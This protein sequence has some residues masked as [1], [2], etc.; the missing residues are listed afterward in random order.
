MRKEGHNVFV[1]IVDI[2]VKEQFADEFREAV[3]RQGHN[4]ITRE[5][6]CLGFDILQDPD[7][8]TRFTLYETYTDATTFH[9]VHRT[10]AHFK[11]YAQTT[12]AWVESKSMRCL[13]KIWPS[14]G[15]GA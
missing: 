1:V 12:A 13:L 3:L 15:S 10:T 8:Q 5:K 14:E 6:G 2:V 4:S 11:E 7:D 9:D